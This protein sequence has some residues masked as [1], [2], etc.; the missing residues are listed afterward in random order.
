LVPRARAPT[1]EAALPL[2]HF[3]DGPEDDDDRKGFEYDEEA[4][5]ELRAVLAEEA[6]RNNVAK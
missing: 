6:R 2:D 1:D 5:F 3:F 4:A